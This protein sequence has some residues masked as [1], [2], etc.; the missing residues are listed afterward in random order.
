MNDDTNTNQGAEEGAEKVI[1]LDG[2]AASATSGVLAV[3]HPDP[4]VALMDELDRVAESGMAEAQAQALADAMKTGEGAVLVD[5]S[6][7]RAE[8]VE[9]RMPLD[10]AERV[11]ELTEDEIKSVLDEG[12]VVLGVDLAAG[13]DETETLFNIVR[14]DLAHRLPV[15][16]SEV[17]SQTPYTA[18][19]SITVFRG[20]DGQNME[21]VLV[22]QEV[23]FAGEVS[24]DTIVLTNHRG[25]VL[26]AQPFINPLERAA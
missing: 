8:A 21:L 4:A 6:T 17:E 5:Y 16:A 24:E 9:L 22:P 25:L 14:L 2:T 7:G 19:G 18:E 20:R 11:G 10:L 15:V 26:V 1:A 23:A 13:P 12:A 3:Q